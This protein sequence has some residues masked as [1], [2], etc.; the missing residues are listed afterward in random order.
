MQDSQYFLVQGHDGTQWR[1]EE[2]VPHTPIPRVRQL[3]GGRWESS[4]EYDQ[5]RMKVF[6]GNR[7][8]QGKRVI[9]IGLKPGTTEQEAQDALRKIR[10]EKAREEQN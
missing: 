3:L 10:E 7:G 4:K 5:F 2:I 9:V 1:D 6:F 8:N